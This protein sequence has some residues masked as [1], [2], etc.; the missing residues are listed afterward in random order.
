MYAIN[1]FIKFLHLKMSYPHEIT[2]Q[3]DSDDCTYM[4]WSLLC[5]KRNICEFEYF[6]LKFLGSQ[7]S[8]FSKN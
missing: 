6:G 3:D 4:E 2:S 8:L 1:S 7:F 5:Q